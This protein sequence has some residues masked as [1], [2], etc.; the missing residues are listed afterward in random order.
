ME[1]ILQF[2]LHNSRKTVKKNHM[3]QNYNFAYYKLLFSN[4]HYK[5]NWSQAKPTQPKLIQANST[6]PNTTQDNPGQ[7]N[8]IQAN[9]G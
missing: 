5:L 2:L 1:Y 4:I 7:L 6:Q 3:L 9:P 8:P